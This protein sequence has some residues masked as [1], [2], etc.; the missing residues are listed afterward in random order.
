MQTCLDLNI[1]LQ[2]PDNVGNPIITF[3]FWHV[4]QVHISGVVFTQR[5]TPST[6]HPE[7]LEH[8]RPLEVPLRTA[9]E[10]VDDVTEREFAAVLGKEADSLTTRESCHANVI[11]AAIGF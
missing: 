5:D 3:L 2:P 10:P 9:V 6:K 1:S 11:S 8:Q 4:L 7:K